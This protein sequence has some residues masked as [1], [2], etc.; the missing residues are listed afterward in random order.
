MILECVVV[1][2]GWS[3]A[4]GS[5]VVVIVFLFVLEF[6]SQ[7]KA[8]LHLVL[9]VLMEGAWSFEDLLVLL[10]VVMLGARFMNGGGNVV[11]SATAILTSFGPF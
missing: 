8:V 4:F 5:T 3:A 7:A 11:W 2:L 9:S 1:V 10:I 6:L